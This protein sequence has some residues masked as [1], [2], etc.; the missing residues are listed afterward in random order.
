L[1]TLTICSIQRFVKA[2][3]IIGFVV[4]GERLRFE[5]NEGAAEKSKLKISARL[6]ELAYRVIR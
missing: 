3:G 1:P 6:L 4:L 2:G 5:I